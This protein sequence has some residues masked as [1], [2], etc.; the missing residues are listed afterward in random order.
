[1][2]QEV[3]LDELD[4][5]EGDLR[6]VH[7]VPYSGIAVLKHSNGVIKR[8]LSFSGGLEEGLCCDFYAN[9]QLEREWN[10]VRGRAEGKITEWYDNGA[11]RSI[12]IYEFGAE[13]EYNEWDSNGVLIESRKL[14]E[15]S[16]LMK[17]V[18]QMRN[19]NQ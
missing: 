5:G 8:R 15:E 3:D 11:V 7:D 10:A 19:S 2:E 1:M 13:L 6:T 9:G 14:D 16:E 12:G 18:V 4:W 17:Y